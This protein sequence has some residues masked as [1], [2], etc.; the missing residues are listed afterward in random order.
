[1]RP[2]HCRLEWSIRG[3]VGLPQTLLANPGYGFPFTRLQL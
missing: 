1:M 3:N 2:R